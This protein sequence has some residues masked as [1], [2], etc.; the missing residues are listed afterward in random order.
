M[1]RQAEESGGRAL[2]WNLTAF[3]P[4]GEQNTLRR[5][6]AMKKGD[7]IVAKRKMLLDDISLEVSK[8]SPKKPKLSLNI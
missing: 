5:I 2:N 1:L 8:S 4:I 6:W 3:D 7:R